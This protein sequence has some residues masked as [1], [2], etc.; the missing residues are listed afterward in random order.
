MG[1]R[2]RGRRTHR[3]GGD[4][5]GNHSPQEQNVVLNSTNLV[6]FL[7]VCVHERKMARNSSLGENYQMEHRYFCTA[8]S[9]FQL[10]MN[11]NE[12]LRVYFC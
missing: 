9:F 1:T 12:R 6:N 10:G 5:P 4:A 8:N 3:N 11:M 7:C 2:G